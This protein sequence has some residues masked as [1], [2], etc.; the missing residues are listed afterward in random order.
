MSFAVT[1][2]QAQAQVMAQTAGKFEQV[3][4]TLDSTLKRLMGELE[5]LR[6]QWKGLGGNSFEQVKQQWSTDQA[7]LNRALTE[8]AQAIRT[9]GTQYDSTDTSASDRLSGV[10]HGVQLPL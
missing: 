9:S 1:T 4:Q 5:V 8:T 7:A 3:S 2:T 10:H 6:T